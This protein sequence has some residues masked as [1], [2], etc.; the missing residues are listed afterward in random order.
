MPESLTQRAAHYHRVAELLHCQEVKD[1]VLDEP[2]EWKRLADEV[3][4]LEAIVAS[5]KDSI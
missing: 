2:G 3:L 5:S 1:V 4:K